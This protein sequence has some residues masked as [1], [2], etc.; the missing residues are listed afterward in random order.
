MITKCEECGN[1]VDLKPGDWISE[2][3]GQIAQDYGKDVELCRACFKKGWSNLTPQDLINNP[4]LAAGISIV[5]PV[6]REDL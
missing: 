4:E 2:E 1:E 3:I 5:S 6:Q